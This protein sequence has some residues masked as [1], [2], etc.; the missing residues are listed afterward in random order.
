MFIA[1]F[2]GQKNAQDNPGAKI[3]WLFPSSAFQ[4][5]RENCLLL[6]NLVL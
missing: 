4:Q 2:L 6:S 3:G 1:D 5:F